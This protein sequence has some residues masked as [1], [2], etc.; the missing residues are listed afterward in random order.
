MNTDVT[1]NE[2]DGTHDDARYL[3]CPGEQPFIQGFYPRYNAIGQVG[4]CG[5]LSAQYQ[6][7]HHGNVGEREDKGAQERKGDRCAIGLNILPS[8]PCKLKMGR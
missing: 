5:E 1:N 3:E 2:Y 4:F 7:A 6:A 8:I